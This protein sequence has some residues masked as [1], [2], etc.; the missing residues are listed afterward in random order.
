MLL[1]VLPEV[2]RLTLPDVLLELLWLTPDEV[3]DVV[4]PAEGVLLVA[5][6]DTV[7]ELLTR[8][9]VV[10]VTLL[11]TGAVAVVLREDDDVAV[12]REGVAGIVVL[13]DSVEAEVLR[14]G[15]VAVPVLPLRTG[16]AAV[17]P[18]FPLRTGADV[19]ELPLRTEVP[20]AVPD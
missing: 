17:P 10:V 11:R 12:L 15:V 18:A 20:D 8:V 2:L 5:P 9:L 7:P 13:R 14:E 3:L 4:L 19:A 1:P 6:R 16:V